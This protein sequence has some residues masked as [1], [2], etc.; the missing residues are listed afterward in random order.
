MAPQSKAAYG[1]DEF[2]GILCGIPARAAGFD[3][4]CRPG[5]DRVWND[6]AA[7]NKLSAEK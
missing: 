4:R 5:D 7:K 1:S 2:G 6:V 3:A